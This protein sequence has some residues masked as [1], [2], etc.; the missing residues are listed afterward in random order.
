MS[1]EW[2]SNERL[3]RWWLKRRWR[4]ASE[5]VDELDLRPAL[6]TVRQALQTAQQAIQAR[7]DVLAT[8]SH[9]L[10]TPLSVIQINAE[11][12]RRFVLRTLPPASAS[13]LAERLQ[14]IE[15]ASQQA[16]QL[17]RDLL[18]LA[19][20]ET[21]GLAI[22]K[23]CI[24]PRLLIEKAMQQLRPFAKEKHLQLKATMEFESTLACDEKRISQVL[25]NLLSNALRFTPQSG[26]IS[27]GVTTSTEG[28]LFYVSDTGPGI[29]PE[30]MPHLFDRYWQAQQTRGATL[31]LG[32]SIAKGII[33]RHGG[34][35]WAESKLGQGT[36]FYF[37][38]PAGV[39]QDAAKSAMLDCNSA[40]LRS[41]RND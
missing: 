26:C 41:P 1:G 31:G 10:K 16:I 2:M 28:A 14:S 38:I 4:R 15:R 19:K 25:T 11:L 7:D 39:S 34:R 12:I 29:P 18:D 36:T 32:L 9:D 22:E 37:T 35:I 6:Q 5:N 20:I 40:Q 8:V 3:K 23:T 17:T 21:G 27:L 24:T 30:N 33:E 13:M